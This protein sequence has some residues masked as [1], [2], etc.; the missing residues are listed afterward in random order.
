MAPARCRAPQ[1]TPHPRPHRSARSA[2]ISSNWHSRRQHRCRRLC[3][4]PR[5]HSRACLEC[6]R[7]DRGRSPRART[8][9]DLGQSRAVGHDHNAG[10]SRRASCSLRG[11]ESRRR[12]GCQIG[13]AGGGRASRCAR[14]PPHKVAVRLYAWPRLARPPPQSPAQGHHHQRW[15]LPPSEVWLLRCFP[16][17]VPSPLYPRCCCCKRMS[18]SWTS[19]PSF[20]NA[21]GCWTVWASSLAHWLHADHR[22]VSVERGMP[23]AR[24]PDLAASNL[25]GTATGGGRMG[26]FVVRFVL[27]RP[28]VAAPQARRHGCLACASCTRRRVTGATSGCGGCS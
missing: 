9:R 13:C 11:A 25:E 27:L 3:C 7:A 5:G 4:G 20:V 21:T 15:N 6:T 19:C 8:D 24:A 1:P 28:R 18:T 17:A 23:A 2:P 12:T 16:W 22:R 10:G 26:H 14:G